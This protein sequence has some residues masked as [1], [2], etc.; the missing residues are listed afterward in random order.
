MTT[1][2]DFFFV[3]GLPNNYKYEFV[4]DADANDTTDGRDTI[5]IE[6]SRPNQNSQQNALDVQSRSLPSG[7]VSPSHVGS[8]TR[9][10]F[11]YD[12]YRSIDRSA[13]SHSGT[14]LQPADPTHVTDRAAS[15]MS[16]TSRGRAS[17]VISRMSVMTAT[18]KT[19]PPSAM[20][21]SHCSCLVP[22]RLLD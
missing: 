21:Y 15:S 16:R 13:S 20:L 1:I 8:R 19:R 12:T 17:K 9:S 3:A 4:A 14:L 22:S 2:A 7:L 18:S 10:T 11:S 6:S 5:A